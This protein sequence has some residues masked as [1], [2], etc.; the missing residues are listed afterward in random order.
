MTESDAMYV[1]VADAR[2]ERASKTSYLRVLRALKT[3]RVSEG[4]RNAALVALG[5][6]SSEFPDTPYIAFAPK[7]ATR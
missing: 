4:A 6:H 3:L 1:L 2:R 7:T 5:Y